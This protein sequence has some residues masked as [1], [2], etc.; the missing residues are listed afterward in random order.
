M[1]GGVGGRGVGSGGESELGPKVLGVLDDFRVELEDGVDKGLGLRVQDRGVQFVLV[2]PGVGVVTRHVLGLGWRRGGLDQRKNLM[3]VLV[4]TFDGLG[5]G[6]GGR[7]GGGEGRTH[8]LTDR[9]M[10]EIDQECPA[11]GPTGLVQVQGSFDEVGESR[12]EFDRGIFIQILVDNRGERFGGRLG[13]H[14][15]ILMYPI[16]TGLY[17]YGVGYGSDLFS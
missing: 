5:G 2:E 16:M 11:M 17:G 4:E 8:K 3:G 6:G 14:G 12:G 9:V 10:G 13:G 7:G 1:K 15:T